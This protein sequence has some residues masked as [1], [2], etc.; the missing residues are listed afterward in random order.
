[1][2]HFNLPLGLIHQILNILARERVNSHPPAPCHITHNLFSGNWIATLSTEGHG[3]AHTLYT[4][5]QVFCLR[6]GLWFFPLLFLQRLF[7]RRN[8]PGSTFGENLAGR[9]SS[10]SQLSIKTFQ[11]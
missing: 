7:F 8:V 9:I 5:Y 11:L 6:I 1:P 3:V 10:I 2:F 4:N